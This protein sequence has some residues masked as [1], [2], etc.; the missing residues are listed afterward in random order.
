MTSSHEDRAIR[1]DHRS[2][3]PVYGGYYWYPTPGP[4]GVQWSLLTCEDLGFASDQATPTFG[5]R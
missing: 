2:I 3:A 1:K 4:D 5:P